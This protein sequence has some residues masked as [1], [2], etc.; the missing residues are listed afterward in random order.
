[1]LSNVKK[2][3]IKKESPL[4]TIKDD[5]EN[6]LPVSS[7]L[8]ANVNSQSS[9]TAK[10]SGKSSSLQTAGQGCKQKPSQ[11]LNQ[12]F[13]HVFQKNDE[14]VEERNECVFEPINNMKY[15]LNLDYRWKY[16]LIFC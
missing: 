2:R 5:E 16:K 9:E 1:M 14:N 13:D 8:K 6:I 4:E 12:L 10:I 15:P 3:S 11:G 7:F